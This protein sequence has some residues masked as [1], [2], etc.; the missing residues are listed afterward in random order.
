VADSAQ[1]AK[2]G[3]VVDAAEPAADEERGPARHDADRGWPL[4]DPMRTVRWERAQAQTRIHRSLKVWRSP[5][6]GAGAPKKI[7]RKTE[8]D[9]EKEAKGLETRDG[10]H[11]LGRHGPQ[12]SDQ[13][14]QDRITTG[15]AADGAF[16]PVGAGG[17]STK[18]ASHKDYVETR[19]AAVKTADAALGASK[20]LVAPLTQA[21][22]AAATAFV[23]EPSGPK[24]GTL[25]T[26]MQT[27]KTNVDTAAKGIT[28]P[29]ADKLSVTVQTPPIRSATKEADLPALVARM[30]LA[31]ASYEIVLD[32]K[33][34]VG[35]GFQGDGSAKTVTDPSHTDK[36]KP[37]KTGEGNDKTKAMPAPTKTRTT[38]D[39]TGGAQPIDTVP[40]ASGWKAAQHFPTEAPTGISY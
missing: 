35:S 16:S 32:H 19:D 14:L 15:V 25:S 5:I 37:A 20:A 31:R 28:N 11:S 18:F 9:A 13:Q 6:A 38:F 30:V 22:L 26:A 23:K 27:A 17:S 24:K 12:V 8:A 4:R 2:T 21:Y 40:A 39:V 10:G 29:S 34:A 36:S 1:R 7:F 3:A 33:R